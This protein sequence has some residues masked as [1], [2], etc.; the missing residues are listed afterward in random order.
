M[1]VKRRETSAATARAWI[2][3]PIRS[4]TPPD[5]GRRESSG[6]LQR[7]D[8]EIV[9]REPDRS[10]PIRIIPEQACTGLRRFIGPMIL[11]AHDH[12]H[13]GMIFVMAERERMPQGNRNSSSSCILPNKDFRRSRL[14]SERNRRTVAGQ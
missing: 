9:D 10:A 2:D 5:T 7:L 14:T 4:D 12:D 11:M 6:T 8:Q 3:G 13:I 1:Y